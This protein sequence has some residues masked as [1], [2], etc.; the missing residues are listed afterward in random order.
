LLGDDS[1]SAI[2][3]VLLNFSNLNFAGARIE[4]RTNNKEKDSRMLYTDDLAVFSFICNHLK[5]IIQIVNIPLDGISVQEWHFLKQLESVD[6]LI[7]ISF[8]KRGS[9]E[10]D[11][12]ETD[13]LTEEQIQLFS[14][15]ITKS[16]K[17]GNLKVLKNPDICLKKCLDELKKVK[18]KVLQM[19]FDEADFLLNS[20]DDNLTVETLII[21]SNYFKPSKLFSKIKSENLT[22]IIRFK[23]SHPKE[24]EIIS[25]DSVKFLLC[26]VNYTTNLEEIFNY[27]K[28]VFPN[29]ETFEIETN[30]G[31]SSLCSFE[32]FNPTEKLA[33]SLKECLKIISRIEAAGLRSKSKGWK[34]SIKLTVKLLMPSEDTTFF[35]NKE[36]AKSLRNVIHEKIDPEFCKTLDDENEPEPLKKENGVERFRKLV[37]HFMVLESKL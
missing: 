5:K 17:N 9:V 33:T 35:P 26:K 25:N 21:K 31:I 34:A 24:D 22:F 19:E 32:T 8:F 23:F 11:G 28:E 4:F 12:V 14:D 37:D 2:E 15:L 6:N 1:L 30:W 29:L 27:V 3:N 13:V 16:T 10:I 7:E 36:I 20:E 18:L